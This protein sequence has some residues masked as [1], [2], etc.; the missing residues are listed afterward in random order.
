MVC[1]CVCVF[2]CLCV[3]VRSVCLCVCVWSVCVVGSRCHLH[4][5]F[6]LT[7]GGTGRVD[8]TLGGPTTHTHARKHAPTRTRAH[9]R[10]PTHPHPRVHAHQETEVMPR[11]CLGISLWRHK[12]RTRNSDQPR[13]SR[14]GS[15]GEL[16]WWRRA[17]RTAH[18][19]PTSSRSS[20]RTTGFDVATAVPRTR[21]GP[22][23]INAATKFSLHDTPL[24]LWKYSAMCC[25]QGTPGQVAGSNAQW[26]LPYYRNALAVRRVNAPSATRT[27][28]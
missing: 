22:T 9:V 17:R 5:D 28:S 16:L 10:T 15:A 6:A 18:W 13:W 11:Q 12:S 26:I 25:V 23:A 8:R 1:L 24:A 7:I 20:D 2:L 21:P 4:S 3:C 27:G 14:S 19:R